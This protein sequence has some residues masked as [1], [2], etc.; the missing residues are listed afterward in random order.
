MNGGLEQDK[1]CGN[2][3][4]PQGIGEEWPADPD[5]APRAGRR[6][7]AD[8]PFEGFDDCFDGAAV[9]CFCQHQPGE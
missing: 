2:A 7:R 1:G 9:F 4:D 8:R 3:D 5:P 6:G